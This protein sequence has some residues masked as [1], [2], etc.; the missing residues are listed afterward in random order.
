M[1]FRVFRVMMEAV[2]TNESTQRYIL[3][4]YKIRS[5]LLTNYKGVS[6]SGLPNGIALK[7]NNSMTKQSIW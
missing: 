1:K 3:E 2:R 5:V 6:T 4:D 7:Q